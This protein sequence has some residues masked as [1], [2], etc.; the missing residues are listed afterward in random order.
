M[1]KWIAM[2]LFPAMA[3][4]QPV[5]EW[6]QQIGVS[7]DDVQL[8]QAWAG[9]LNSAQPG[10]I[11]L[12]L[13]GTEDLAIFDRTSRKFSTFLSINGS[14]VYSPQYEELLPAGLDGWV[15]FRDFNCDGKKDIF[16]HT[17][18]GIKIYEN[19]SNQT[20]SWAIA[21]DPVFTEGFSGPINLQVNVIDLPA[22][23]D[24]DDDG[25][26]DILVFDFGSGGRVEYHQNVS[27]ENSGVCGIE[28]VRQ[29]KYW[30]NFEE[31]FCGEFAFSEPCE[32]TAKVQ[33][34]A[35]KSLTMFDMDNDGD[36]EVLVGQEDCNPLFLLPNN[37]TSE[38]ANME[39]FSM[40]PQS[41]PVSV[42]FPAAYLEDVDF[43][44]KKDLL[45]SSNFFFNRNNEIDFQHS[46]SFY[47]NTGSNEFPAFDFQTN[48]F[49]QAEMIDVGENAVP[50]TADFDRDGDL[51]LFIGYRGTNAN[52]F[53]GSVWYFENIGGSL[54]PEYKLVTNDFLSIR[55]LELIEIKPAFADLNADGRLDFT[56]AGSVSN[57]ATLFVL[58][59]KSNGV[60]SFDLNDR[61]ALD[62]PLDQDDTYH[63]TPIDGDTQ[64]DLL[65]G[66]LSGQLDLY[67]NN[68][69][70]LATAFTL[71][72]EGFYG[73]LADFERKFL[74]ISVADIDGNNTSDLI[75]GDQRGFVSYY[76]D[77]LSTLQNPV[78]AQPI[79]IKDAYGLHGFG[80]GFYL[81]A[82]N[83][84]SD[85][86]PSIFIGLIGGGIQLLKNLTP[87]SGIEPE[88]S[89]EVIIYP[90]PLNQVNLLTVSANQS[91]TIQVLNMIGQPI[92][93][94]ISIQP[95]IP[96]Q[97][98]VLTLPKG[99]YLLAMRAASSATSTSQFVIY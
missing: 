17:L 99:S 87:T 41:D 94:E 55:Q 69:G 29:T 21:V 52:G 50:T 98:D 86:K 97:I 73:I 35:G 8:A 79:Q 37:G 39:S 43:D 64:P 63:F 85:K 74:T 72:A 70:A 75:T 12:D 28:F 83:V 10:K 31:C 26:L 65:I 3:Y 27:M 33:H 44:G 42:N 59:N 34:V 61:I 2:V 18:F 49:L 14:F 23:D 11:D 7:I 13:D 19:T 36:R 24:I 53:A 90:N 76:P 93:S 48:S 46:L 67:K 9:G 80:N 78:D 88:L 58:L 16:T 51:D 20:L 84:Y 91:G 95:G 38:T 89:L 15:L 62:V 82:G 96:V 1:G 30:G 25:D 54:A 32:G 56:F 4:S 92:S 66:R 60:F 40:F 57:K 77:F 6:D 47:K 5:F 22:I 45:T 81:T 71:E 68:G